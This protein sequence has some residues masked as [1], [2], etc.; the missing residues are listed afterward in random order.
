MPSIIPGYEYD[1]FISYRHK[2]NKYDRWVSLFV[3][4]LRKEMEATFK[5]DISIY[6]DENPHD[7]IL[8]TQIVDKSLEKKL[9]SVIF[10]PIL[11]QTY[12]DSKSYAWQGE[13][14]KFNA[15]SQSDTFGRD[16]RLSN[17]NVSSRILPVQIHD[18]DEADQKLLYEEMKSPLRSVQFIFRSAGVNRPLMP[19]DDITK[20]L[21][22]TYYR[23]EINKVANAA[24]EIIMSVK[25]DPEGHTHKQRAA[26]D[27]KYRRGTEDGRL[28]RA[29][30]VS[31]KRVL[32]FVA[33]SSLLLVVLAISWRWLKTEAKTEQISV[34]SNLQL[35]FPIS[36]YNGQYALFSVSQDGSLLGYSSKQGIRLRSLANFSEKQIKGTEGAQQF[37]FS[38]D[39]DFI[40]FH[41]T[42]GLF[43][44]N[45]KDET[46]MLLSAV[47]IGVGLSWESDDMIYFGAGLGSGGI[48]RVKSNGENL[49]KLTFLKDSV[50]ENGH[51]YP[52]LLPDKETI[53]FTALGPSGG[54]I[55]S[56]LAVKSI[57][58]GSIKFIREGAM[59]GKYLSNGKILF[60]TNEGTIYVA[61][62]DL[63]ELTFT[64]DPVAV[65]SGVNTATWGGA[66]YLTVSASGN[67]AYMPRKILTRRLLQTRD[68][69]GKIVSHDSLSIDVLSK[70]GH[71]WSGLNSMRN[72]DQYLVVTGRVQGSSDI[73]V[74]DIKGN[75][76]ERISFS[77][78]EEEFP[79]SSVDGKSVTYTRA[80]NGKSRLIM[81]KDIGSTKPAKVLMK[82]PRHIHVTSWSLDGKWLA[83]Y[84]YSEKNGLD[85]WL[86]SPSE[87]RYM[88]I[89]TTVGNASNAR[90]SPDGRWVA[91]Q[92]T[93]GLRSEIYVIAFPSLTDKRQIT[94]DGGE[95]PR[96]DPAGK[97]LYF[98]KA[99]SLYAV[100]VDLTNDFR[101]AKPVKLFSGVTD[102]NPVNQNKFYV[103][104]EHESQDYRTLN[105]VSNWFLDSAF[106]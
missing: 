33:I 31:R 44:V 14:V 62:F 69:S 35:D 74:V 58:S 67:M 41:R 106:K 96:W 43:K 97:F 85:A 45:V 24:K 82:W 94:I 47:P 88:P 54:H 25:G 92:G 39:G 1:I 89:D 56:R 2:D 79:I 105:L 12:C 101:K 80:Y 60:A 5:E 38:P 29:P 3:E 13:F 17:G 66:A 36:D 22:H 83:A 28:V 87:N 95:Q 93:Q 27:S 63:K 48:W 75:D 4:N 26:K 78:A 73:W 65:L 77:P 18:L 53:L 42:G 50:G 6:F 15:N 11:S 71:G 8:E 7:G 21:N 64:A 52:Q 102:F 34:Y 68:R 55:D 104:N 72:E 51:T 20:N 10:I 90:F 86:I 103:I 100:P 57:R 32:Q 49:E 61:P 76:A 81:T 37:A 9:N 59:F 16:L 70:I 30:L 23:D 98:L 19:N 40:V 84:D 99:G 91:Y 46:I